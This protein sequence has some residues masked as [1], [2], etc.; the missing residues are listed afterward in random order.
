MT[1]P[2]YHIF[3]F[4][5]DALSRATYRRIDPIHSAI[6]SHPFRPPPQWQWLSLYSM[7][8][9]RPDIS[10]STLR[11]KAKFQRAILK[12]LT[13]LTAASMLFAMARGVG[14]LRRN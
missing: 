6:H 12:T 10:Y 13:G 14:R 1:T 8:T 11:T 5:D 2:W 9:F 3:K 7:V 4:I